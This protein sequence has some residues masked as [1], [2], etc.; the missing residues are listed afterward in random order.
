MKTGL[1]RRR[2]PL[3]LLAFS[4]S[5]F[6]LAADEK[7]GLITASTVLQLILSLALI[8][9]LIFA[10]GWYARRIQG[11]SGGKQGDLQVLA[12]TP[13]GAKERVVLLRVGEDKILL[14]VAPGSVRML[15]RFP[16]RAGD[17]AA[18]KKFSEL[19]NSADQQHAG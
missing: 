4:A 5:P 16:L 2:A 11:F 19:L 15:G 14:G 6:A 10:L 9:A 3:A 12:A 18:E 7:V 8:V 1:G 17:L 13:V